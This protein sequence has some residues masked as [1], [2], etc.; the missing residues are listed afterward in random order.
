[1]NSISHF[2]TTT[3]PYV[4]S[5]PHI[6][7]AQEFILSDALVR[8]YKQQGHHVLFQSGTDDNSTKNVLAAKA[9]GV[10]IT[11][12]V[13]KHALQF[14][15]LL[16]SLNIHPDI[17]VRT[18]APN[19]TRSVRRFLKHLKTEDTY[20]SSYSGLYC[21]GCEDFFLEGDLVDGL[22]P[23][24]QKAP[25]LIEEKNIFFRLSS[26]QNKIF[27]LIEN[28]TIKITPQSKKKETLAFISQGLRDISLSR[29]SL[30]TQSW[31]IPYPNQS[32]QTVYVWI[33]ALINY[34]SGIG[35]GT[36]S[37]WSAIWNNDVYKIHVIG[38][39]VWKFHAIYWPALL[40]SV[41]LP[42]PN[43]IVIHGF[44]TN[45]GVKIS[46][47]LGNSIDPSDVIHK[48]GIDAIR[49]YLLSGLSWENDADFS[50]KNLVGFY[51]AELANKLGNL[52]SRILKLRELSHL[53]SSAFEIV[54][55]L[56][57]EINE[58]KP[59]VLLKNG[60]RSELV[61]HLQTWLLELNRVQG[62][63]TPLIPDGAERLQQLI[64]QN[65]P[66]SGQLFPRC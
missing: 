58:T 27:D 42:L 39:N 64:N 1:M 18:S 12:F 62:L 15:D 29:S 65:T 28:D 34:I 66:D 33:D 24:H 63:L 55:R 13:D 41:G 26:Y 50:E 21:T 60:Q 52:C 3:I 46:K 54:N 35:Y 17:F 25:E 6:G 10:P 14:R 47:S 59:W 56:N 11:D 30:R 5:K 43:E 38:K 23:D 19:H 32:D 20:E 8:F 48:Y 61:G 9:A 49:L 51:N 22:C 2:I 7:H 40:L 31:G 45:N 36:N 53:K 16:S 44:L 4:N 37:E 57:V